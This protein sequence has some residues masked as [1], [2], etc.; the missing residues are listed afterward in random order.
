MTLKLALARSLMDEVPLAIGRSLPADQL[1]LV[2]LLEVLERQTVA[3]IQHFFAMAVGSAV[4]LIERCE[5]AGLVVRTKDPPSAE[6][7]RKRGATVSRATYVGITAKAKQMRRRA[8][9]QMR[10]LSAE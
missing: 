10:G 8:R 4:K 1:A 3:E 5:A 6:A 9:G 2:L 7:E